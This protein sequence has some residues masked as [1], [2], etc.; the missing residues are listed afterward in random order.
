MKKSST[1]FLQVVVMLLGLGIIAAML[2]EPQL[3]G[4]NVNAT[5]FEIYFNP[6]VILVYL[7]SIPFFVALYKSFR[8][9]GYARQN[10]VFSP[11]AVKALSVI[12]YCMFITAGAIVA[13]DVYIRIAAQSSND[14]PAGAIM[15][16]LIATLISVV[17]GTGAALFEKNLQNAVDMKSENDLTV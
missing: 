16:G 11:M 3:E 12:K 10:K 9:L 13:V 15:L 6:F 5:N 2:W 1:I 17:I 7:G 4:A 8:V 14:D